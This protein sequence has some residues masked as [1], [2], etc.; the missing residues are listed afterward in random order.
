VD[1]DNEADVLFCPSLLL[2]YSILS[3][4]ISYILSIDGMLQ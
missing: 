2:V 1:V 3:C 4:F